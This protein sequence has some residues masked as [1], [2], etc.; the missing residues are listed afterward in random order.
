MVV[1]PLPVTACCFAPYS[2]SLLLTKE[3]IISF[4]QDLR[5]VDEF[6]VGK[7]IHPNATNPEFDE[8]FHAYVKFKKAPNY[9]W[10]NGQTCHMRCRHTRPYPVLKL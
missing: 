2:Y 6:S 5:G 10:G 8:H 1:I 4:L 3:K 9:Q 7:E